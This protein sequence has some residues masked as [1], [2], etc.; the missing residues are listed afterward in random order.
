MKHIC[1][2]HNDFISFT[3]IRNPRNSDSSSGWRSALCKQRPCSE[4]N[5][6]TNWR[7]S[8][9]QNWGKM[10]TVRSEPVGYPCEGRDLFLVSCPHAKGNHYFLFNCLLLH[11]FWTNENPLHISALA[12]TVMK[13]VNWLKIICSKL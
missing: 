10:K 13:R 6:S 9:K 1:H 12:V 11:T 7:R 5:K 2:R 4:K 3:G 8:R